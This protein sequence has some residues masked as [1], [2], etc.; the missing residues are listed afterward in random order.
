M[1]VLCP[2]LL[3]EKGRRVEG[4]VCHEKIK[5]DSHETLRASVQLGG[6]RAAGGPG[7]GPGGWRG[8]AWLCAFGGVGAPGEGGLSSS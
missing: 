7:C 3:A 2:V 8:A 1:E 5:H 4:F 6:R